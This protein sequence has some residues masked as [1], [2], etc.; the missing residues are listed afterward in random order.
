MMDTSS[1]YLIAG[2]VLLHLVLGF[3]YVLYKITKA[4]KSEEP[5]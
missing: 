3:G 2:I 4:G 5:D 1:F